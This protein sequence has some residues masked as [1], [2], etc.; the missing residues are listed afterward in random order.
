[1]KPHRTYDR[2]IALLN[3]A[4]CLGY[5]LLGVL[6]PGGVAHGQIAGGHPLFHAQSPPGLIGA[7]RAAGPGPVGNYFQAVEIRGP[8]GLQVT[9]AENGQ[10]TVPRNLPVTVGLAVGRIYRLKV[11]GIPGAEGVELFPSLELIDRLYPPP[12]QERHFPIVVELHPDDLTLAIQG[13]YVTRVVYLE[14]PQRA[15]PVRQENGEQTWFEVRSDQDPLAV[16]DSLGRPLIILRMGGR[17]PLPDEETDP[18]F[19][20][21]SPPL[22]VYP[23]R[24][25]FLPG[26]PAGGS[27]GSTPPASDGEGREP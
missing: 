19:L 18:R 12:G 4:L 17:V 9:F 27:Q 6:E 5:G 16:A 25:K 1:M 14:D 7:T 11:T 21:G 15:L 23:P 8:S 10:F 20:F 26:P 13:K 2:V 3:L 24:V 22:V